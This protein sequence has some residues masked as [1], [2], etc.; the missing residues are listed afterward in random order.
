MQR[1]LI[2]AALLLGTFLSI[3]VAVTVLGEPSFDRYL[4]SHASS[5]RDGAFGRL[6]H[7]LSTIGYADWFAPIVAIVALLLAAVRRVAAAVELILAVVLANV[8][9]ALFKQ[10]FRRARPEFS[11]QIVGGYSMPSGHATM[12]FTLVTALLL[13]VPEL[14]RPW[15]AIPLVAYAVLT[16]LS[17]V[18]LGV[19]YTTDVAAGACLGVACALVVDAAVQRRR[20]RVD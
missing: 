10:L 5:L 13:A 7:G 16:A 1:R 15:L 19:H 17:R 14:R 2:A 9:F 18:V 4:D 12:S 8:A 3:A 11:E 6:L 20:T